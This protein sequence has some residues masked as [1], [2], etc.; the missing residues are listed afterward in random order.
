[1][2]SAANDCRT[3][4]LDVPF[5][6]ENNYI[7]HE[8]LNFIIDRCFTKIEILLPN[9]VELWFVKNFESGH[10]KSKWF[11]GVSTPTSNSDSWHSYGEKMAKLNIIG[12]KNSEMIAYQMMDYLSKKSEKVPW[13]EFAKIFET[14]Y[15]GRSIEFFIPKDK[16]TGGRVISKFDVEE[17]K[18]STTNEVRATFRILQ[19][20]RDSG[21]WWTFKRYNGKSTRLVKKA[22]RPKNEQETMENEAKKAALMECFKERFG[23]T[24]FDDIS[25]DAF[26]RPINKSP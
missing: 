22:R 25:R 21:F 12:L 14:G 9:G 6:A 18:T 24:N 19:Y 7:E 15:W 23:F 26:H 2:N 11:R 13:L 3:L 20:E 16:R 5:R 17:S 8:C 1:M 10:G 4:F